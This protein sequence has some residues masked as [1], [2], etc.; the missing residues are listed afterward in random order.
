VSSLESNEW[1]SR[2]EA[3]N[4]LCDI[5]LNHS[6]PIKETGKLDYYMDRLYEKLEDGSLKVQLHALSCIQKLHQQVPFVFNVNFALP[7]FL[8][9]SSFSNKQISSSG[10]L[11]LDEYVSSLPLPIVVQQLC[12]TALHDKDR[13]RVKAFKVLGGLGLGCSHDGVAVAKKHLFPTICQVLF[14]GN[15]SSK[16]DIRVAAVDTLKSLAHDLENNSQIHGE[17][18]SSIHRWSDSL[19][20]QE[21]VKK[22]LL[23]K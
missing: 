19:K 7:A 12:N 6:V 10:S 16:G 4:Q 2:K 13:L 20:Q 21:E 5:L 14:N 18:G 11:F 3:L 17:K 1:T 8:N 9:V 15:G 22:I 23:L